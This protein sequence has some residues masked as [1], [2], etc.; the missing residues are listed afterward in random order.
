MVNTFV[1][2]D[3]VHKCARELDWRRLGKQRVE[4]YQIWRALKGGGGTT[5]CEGVGGARVCS[6][7]DT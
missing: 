4:A 3:D 2:C 5:G 7:D 1:P 6:C